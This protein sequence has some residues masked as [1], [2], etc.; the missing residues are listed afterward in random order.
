MPSLALEIAAKAAVICVAAGLAHV[1]AGRNRVLLRSAIWHVCLVGLVLL[2]LEV[3][4]FPRL[5]LVGWAVATNE[6]RLPD[7]T[8]VGTSIGEMDDV[9]A[10]PDLAQ[11]AEL[12]EGQDPSPLEAHDR[13][14]VPVN[15]AAD[16]GFSRTAGAAAAVVYLLASIVLVIRLA[17]SL[18]AVARLR[19]SGAALS[20][21][22]WTCALGRWQRELGLRAHVELRQSDSVSVPIVVGWRRPAILVPADMARS[23]DRGAIDAVLVHELTHVGRGDY[24]W[25]VL[26]R[27][28]QIVYWPHPF[29]WLAARMVRQ[30]REEVCDA[31]CVHCL[32]DAREYCAI[33]VD[34]ASGLAQRSPVALGMAMAHSS[35]LS[36]RL[37]R[38]AR[39]P[40]TS[41][42]LLAGRLRAGL[43]AGVAIST[44]LLGMLSAVPRTS[45]ADHAARPGKP[46]AETRRDDDLKSARLP[47]VAVPVEAKNEAA[48]KPDD[49]KADSRLPRVRTVKVKRTRFSKSAVQPATLEAF[50]PVSVR[51]RVT[52]VVAKVSVDEGD[53]VKK[54][55]VLALIDVPDIEAELAKD[56]ADLAQAQASVEQAQASL[57]SAEATVEAAAATLKQSEAESQKAASQA[58]FRQTQADRMKELLKNKA[59][60]ERIVEEKEE[61]LAAAEE[62]KTAADAKV[63][64]SKA[65]RERSLAE[66][67]LARAVLKA[68]L[69]RVKIAEAN[70]NRGKAQESFREIRAPIDGVI[71]WKRVETDAL[72]APDGKD[73]LFTVA[74][75]NL[76]IAK[77]SIP[78]RD[79]VKV[80]RGALASVEFD[81]LDGQRI[82]GKVSRV[83]Y[84]VNPADRSITV[85]IAIP[86]REGIL[87]PGMWCRAAVAIG[88]KSDVLSIPA[89]AYV[90][91]TKQVEGVVKN[92]CL[93]VVNGRIVPTEIVLGEY[94]PV[95]DRVEVVDGLKE[96]DEVISPLTPEILGR[97]QSDDPVDVISEPEK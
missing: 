4:M 61:Q 50:D 17:G 62:E 15:R 86:N 8:A 33:L 58:K 41:R 2:P 80:K 77:V 45:S 95:T 14:I 39:C 82:I 79:A 55:E 5:P 71:V 25:N 93:R 12:G 56:E 10:L 85:Q 96:G 57:E 23:D 76:M 16:I 63:Q 53:M 21:P 29:V 38:V 97:V 59:V 36:R 60:D 26:L 89:D 22:L 90:R 32:G 43:V 91:G 65:N 51:S 34:V 11:D 42:Y 68:A 49:Q 54:G 37:S 78:E 40:A 81:S 94:D 19:R 6:E 30:V 20:N 69:L 64:T 46:A 9:A 72:V 75:T 47:G 52:G 27:S 73:P 7:S 92:A 84:R 13:A 31:V 70:L 1:L 35:R 48:T 83:G 44:G 74:P 3:V 18:A 88:E 24:A 87:K 28:A 66:V 67:R